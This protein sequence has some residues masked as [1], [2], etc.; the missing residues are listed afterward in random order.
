MSAS[1]R[2]TLARANFPQVHPLTAE[3]RSKFRSEL[4]AL[5]SPLNAEQ[6][7]ALDNVLAKSWVVDKLR[8]ALDEAG[9]AVV[10][11]QTP[12]ELEQA[13][14]AAAGNNAAH[15]TGQAQ[16][17]RSRSGA[18]RQAAGRPQSLRSALLR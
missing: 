7:A 8:V 13:R 15:A 9:K 5:G 14:Q 12:C 10:I 17:E 6:A 2:D 3:A 4:E 1:V 16:K 11:E 18:Q